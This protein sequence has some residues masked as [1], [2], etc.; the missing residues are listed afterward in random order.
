MTHRVQLS[1][2]HFSLVHTL[3]TIVSTII[4]LTILFFIPAAYSDD[5]LPDEVVK[6]LA[7]QGYERTD[8]DMEIQK[9]EKAQKDGSLTKDGADRLKNLNDA[10]K[11]YDNALDP[12]N[13]LGLSKQAAE[14]AERA[15]KAR[16]YQYAIEAFKK[17]E[18]RGME[19]A[20]YEKVLED[21][22]KGPPKLPPFPS[23]PIAALPGAGLLPPGTELASSGTLDATTQP[24][25]YIGT[26]KG[27]AKL[28]T[29]QAIPKSKVLVT[30][31]MM[32]PWEKPES[33]VVQGSGDRR[34]GGDWF[35]TDALPPPYSLVGT[36]GSFKYDVPIT[37]FGDKIPAYKVAIG[38]DYNFGTSTIPAK[39]ITDSVNV[40]IDD[41]PSNLIGLTPNSDPWKL[42]QTFTA[43]TN[44][45]VDSWTA[46]QN[47]FTKTGPILE[48]R[49]SSQ[50]FSQFSTMFR[51]NI[52]YTE[53]NY[54]IRIAPAP[55]LSSVGWPK[56]ETRP[57]PTFRLPLSL[58]QE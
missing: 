40:S 19:A 13:P 34:K 58:V 37:S 11:R 45:S 52:I 38:V 29:G 48:W 43:K 33:F 27:T 53:P 4:L 57:I 56:T 36:D 54:G 49:A 26:I 44:I 47:T 2:R 41:R 20:M 7:K 24:V 50:D 25:S 16:A 21:L 14:V 35:P 31:V 15:R 22:M 10:N 5:P 32:Q 12:K 55:G 1:A 9:L 17:M 46:W 30:G 42:G 39:K 8:R 6:D 3:V 18:G 51:N 23:L 28:T